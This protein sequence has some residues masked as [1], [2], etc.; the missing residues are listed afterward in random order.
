MRRM[1]ISGL[2]LLPSGLTGFAQTPPAIAQPAASPE[3]VSFLGPFPAVESDEGKADLAILL[4]HQRTRTPADIQRAASEVKLT[5]E[6]YA[7]AS[8]RSLNP[9]QFPKTAALID[10][11]GKDTKAVTDSLKKHFQRP[12]PY[13]TDGRVQPAIERET[14]P[15]YPSGHATRGVI[16][17]IILGELAPE[18]REALLVAG[19]QVGVDRVIGGVHYPS[20]IEAG[21]RLAFRLA[22]AWLADPQNRAA[23]DAVRVAEWSQP[24]KP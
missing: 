19:R 23:V 7:T 22:A 11:V 13:L 24:A 20:D 17:G 5:L 18:R 21:Q 2:L 1:L 14:S 3:W 9:T 6:A 4:W 12:R 10:K 8:G 16:F 15:S